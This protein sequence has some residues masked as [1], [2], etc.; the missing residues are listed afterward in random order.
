MH[1]ETE[2]QKYIEAGKILAEVRRDIW[3]EIKPGMLILNLANKIENEIIKRGGQISF[4]V[5]ISIDDQTAHYTPTFDDKREIKENDLVKIDIGTHIDGY[6]ADS[7]LT[8]CFTKNKL[9]ESVNRALEAATK[10]IKPGLRVSEIGA[11][12]EEIVKKDGLGLIINLT[13]H[14]IGR[15]DFHKEPTIPNIKNN[16]N[17]VLQENEVIAIEPF[18]CEGGG[19]VKESGTVEIFR[20]LQDKQVRSKDA[21]DIL[22]YIKNNFGLY[23]FAKRWLLQKFTPMKVSLAL[24]QLESARAIESYPVLKEQN[25]KKVAQ[26]EHTIIVKEKPIV[27]TPYL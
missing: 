17:Y 7:A 22:E 8:Y 16:S 25:G 18:V 27:T 3:K 21:R 4:P 24:N 11:L 5:N 23:P 12:I 20:Y 19:S 10:I 1:D 15:N 13:G 14:G 26:A 2:I 6:S 9:I